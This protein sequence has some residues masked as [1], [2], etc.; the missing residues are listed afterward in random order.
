MKRI[1]PF[2][3]ETVLYLEAS[4]FRSVR[5]GSDTFGDQ[6]AKDSGHTHMIIDQ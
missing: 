6:R 5:T 3:V 4:Q 1:Y 2:S